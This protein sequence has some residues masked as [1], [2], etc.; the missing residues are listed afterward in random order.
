ME[1]K[2]YV[3]II[4]PHIP[5]GGWND[6]Q[7]SYD[8]IEEAMACLYRYTQ[9]SE[10]LKSGGFDW[11]IVYSGEIIKRGILNNKYEIVTQY[12]MNNR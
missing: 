3:F 9:L 10:K 7:G 5:K 12:V 4:D 8:T 2:Y 1:N 11:H 6:H